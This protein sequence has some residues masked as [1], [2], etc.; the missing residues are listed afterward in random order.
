MLENITYVLVE[1]VHKYTLVFSFHLTEQQTFLVVVLGTSTARSKIRSAR[2]K[3]CPLEERSC[4]KCSKKISLGFR[5]ARYVL[6]KSCA[7]ARSA[8]IFYAR[9]A[10]NSLG[11]EHKKSIILDE[12]F[13]VCSKYFFKIVPGHYCSR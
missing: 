4:S 1:R 9:N 2:S 10:R 13:I 8:R 5:S 6:E 12:L 3:I 7:R 11:I